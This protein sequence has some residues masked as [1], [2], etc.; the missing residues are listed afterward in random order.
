M[1]EYISREDALRELNRERKY[2]ENIN[3]QIKNGIQ[4]SINIIERLPKADVSPV[5]K[6]KSK[7]IQMEKKTPVMRP[8]FE[9]AAKQYM[10]KGLPVFQEDCV[11]YIKLVNY[12]THCGVELYEREQPYCHKCGARLEK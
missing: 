4:V 10:I 9:D 3:V 2:F 1:Y 7:V 12:C 8:V 11:V 6:A 5:T